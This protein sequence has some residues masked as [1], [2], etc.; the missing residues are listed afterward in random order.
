MRIWRSWP[1]GCAPTSPMI[2]GQN[3]ANEKPRRQKAPGGLV[4]ALQDRHMAHLAAGPGLGL[5]V[6]MQA[7]ARLG[8]MSRQPSKS[9]P[10]RLCISTRSVRAPRLPSGSP[11]M[12]RICCSNCEVTAAVE[13]PMAGIVD[14]RR[15]LVDQQLGAAGVS[16]H[17]HLHRQHADIIQRLGDARRACARAS[18][19]IGADRRRGRGASQDVMLVD[20]LGRR[21]RRRNRRRGRAPRP[22]KPRGEGHEA[23]EDRRLAAERAEGRRRGPSPRG[24]EPGPCRHSRTA[25]SSGSTAARSAPPRAPAPRRRRPARRARSRCRVANEVLFD[26]P[27]LRQRQH[28]GRRAAPAASR[29][30]IRRAAGMFSN[31]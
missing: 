25:A 11:Q 23:L 29:R 24:S 3:S 8:Q 30:E 7:G 5:A 20:V 18:A 6:E 28:R 10:I 17:E 19:Q 15:D 1:A 16:S 14:A 2:R 26:Q 12:A 27:V 21:P 4:S 9:S 13:R 22:P 31:S